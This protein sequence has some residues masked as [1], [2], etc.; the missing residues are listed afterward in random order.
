MDTYTQNLITAYHEVTPS[1][2]T[3]DI[4]V[5]CVIQNSTW[6]PANM[7]SF[8]SDLALAITGQTE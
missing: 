4:S 5:D 7:S 1:E 6:V 3:T 8:G 2:K